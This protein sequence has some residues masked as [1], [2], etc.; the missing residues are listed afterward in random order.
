MD[1]TDGRLDPK[2][3]KT[4]KGFNYTTAEAGKLVQ[5]N[6]LMVD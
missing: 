4:D 2:V 6:Y 3:Y 5:C 1:V